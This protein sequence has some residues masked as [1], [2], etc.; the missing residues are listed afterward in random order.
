M[1]SNLIFLKSNQ[2]IL[3]FRNKIFIN[4]GIFFPKNW[5]TLPTKD[6]INTIQFKN[7]KYDTQT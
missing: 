1:I 5:K 6:I 7:Q 3:L 4:N 2:K